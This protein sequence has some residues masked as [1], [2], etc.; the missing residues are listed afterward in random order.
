MANE[1]VLEVLRER[2]SVRKFKPDMPPKD[3]IDQ[4]IRAGDP[5]ACQ[6]SHPDQAY[7]TAVP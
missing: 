3:V 6:H 4:I 2:R 7:V 1:V 5:T